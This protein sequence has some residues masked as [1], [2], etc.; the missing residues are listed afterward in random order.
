MF[1]FVLTYPRWHFVQRNEFTAATLIISLEEY[2]GIQPFDCN[3]MNRSDC[4]QYTIISPVSLRLSLMTS[5]LYLYRHPHPLSNIAPL[6][7][8]LHQPF[9]LH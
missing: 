1:C 9:I 6:T 7:H 8:P 3:L 5:S 4:L 2:T